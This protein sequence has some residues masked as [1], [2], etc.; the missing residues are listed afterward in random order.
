M[1]SSA[2][3]N[4][5]WSKYYQK[6]YKTAKYS[7]KITQNILLNLLKKYKPFDKYE[8][9]ELGGGNSCFFEA[10]MKNTKPDKYTIVDNNQLSINRFKEKYQ[11]KYNIEA[12]P[13]NVLD[14]GIK[15]KYEVVLS[16]GLIEHFSSQDR[17]KVV[18]NHF[19]LL[20]PGGIVII[21]FPTPTFLY[22][23]TR[24]C[25]E[26]MNLW[27]FHDETPLKFKEVIPMIEKN[28]VI[29]TRKIN[30]LIFLTQGIIVAKKSVSQSL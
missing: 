23:I 30:W 8:I 9:V 10:I 18:E 24:W 25:S 3:Q 13:E 15:Q 19:K 21:T 28:G 26:K 17:Q 14:I 22:K 11:N 4:T 6:P 12:Y 1:I 29:L 7:R 16:V 5:D 20:K 27:I 2:N